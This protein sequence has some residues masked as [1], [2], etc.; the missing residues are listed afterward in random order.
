MRTQRRS[1]CGGYE[2]I[3]LRDKDVLKALFA[4]AGPMEKR[5]SVALVAS[6]PV[7]E[8][9]NMTYTAYPVEPISPADLR[10]LQDVVASWCEERRLAISDPKAE[11]AR[12]EVYEL[13]HLGVVGHDT[14]L[15][16]IRSI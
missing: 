8:E 12:A 15:E 10:M 9:N 14:L 6:N 7:T 5:R 1:R 13:Y 11:Q 2:V 16:M 4:S 3:N